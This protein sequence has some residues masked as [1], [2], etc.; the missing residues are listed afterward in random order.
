MS[1][2][3]LVDVDG[4]SDLDIVSSTLS[5]L[6]PAR[7]LFLNN[8][9][10]RFSDRSASQM[11]FAAAHGGSFAVLDTFNR[12]TND[13]VF[14][15]GE[16]YFNDRAG[17]FSVDLQ[18]SLPGFDDT[19][20]HVATGDLDG[21]GAVDLFVSN[22]QIDRVWL[23]DGTGRFDDVTG[24]VPGGQAAGS[25]RSVLVDVD[26]DGDL[27]AVTLIGQAPSRPRL[28]VNDGAGRFTDRTLSS[29]PSLMG[30]QTD[31]AAGDV[32]GDLDSDLLVSMRP[33]FFG[34]PTSVVLTND[35]SGNFTAATLR[36][37]S[38]EA[39]V[40]AVL[41]DFDGDGD[42]DA[43]IGNGRRFSSQQNRLYRND[44]VGGFTDVSLTAL[45]LGTNRTTS[46]VAADIDGDGDV[47]LV[48]G[49]NESGEAIRILTNDGSGTFTVRPGTPAI[50]TGEPRVFVA[51]LDGDGD[52][53]VFMQSNF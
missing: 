1:A 20:N 5:G 52:A 29:M 36:P 23:Q 32:D 31:L 7:N 49:Q 15:T 44:G 37:M 12:G 24:A 42:L 14:A 27:D 16:I 34:G 3:R 26:G 11:P 35:G 25:V 13:V 45:P 53:D 8:G 9:L 17:T 2:A 43:F 4:D 30:F 19:I 28:L 6:V 39:S 18:P 47:D 33:S 22:Q 50:T 46:A 51:D 41:R 10:G 21:D 48:L 40:A 38:M